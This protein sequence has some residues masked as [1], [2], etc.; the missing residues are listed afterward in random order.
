MAKILEIMMTGTNNNRL[1]LHKVLPMKSFHNLRNYICD[2]SYYP[3][4]R[5]PFG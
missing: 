1:S 2:E 5:F 4:C 3:F